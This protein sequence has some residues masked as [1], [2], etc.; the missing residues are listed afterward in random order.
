MNELIIAGNAITQD[1]QGRFCIND[2][3]RAAGEQSRH[4][5]SNW[6][7]LQS[8]GDLCKEIE[9]AGIPA[10]LKKQGLGT[11]VCKELVYAYAMWISP[12]FHLKV[13]RAYDDM[14]T[15][16][17]FDPM[18]ALNDPAMMRG[19]L[20]NYSEKVIELENQVHEMAP[21]VEAFELIAVGTNGSLCFRDSA[22]TLQVTE[23]FLKKLLIT[24]KWAYVRPM[25]TSL[26]A[27]SDKLQKGLLEHKITKGEKSD[28]SEWVS[29]QMRITSKGLAQ[30]SEI[31]TAKSN[32]S[33]ARQ[34]KEPSEEALA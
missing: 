7:Q 29:I 4:K 30:L 21:K 15:R 14:V 23:G 9:I 11:F 22:K 16:P 5:P 24:L 32:E 2:L 28:G 6:L 13:I 17:Q 25:G 34:E 19:L 18:K 31:I 8:T 20:L 26:L 27:Y 33:S 1:E 12:A 10:I 3:H